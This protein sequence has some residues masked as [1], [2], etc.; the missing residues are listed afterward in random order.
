M[1]M[2]NEGSAADVALVGFDPVLGDGPLGVL[3][4]NLACAH[5]PVQYV[6]QPVL[7]PGSPP[8]MVRLRPKIAR[9]GRVSSQTKWD[10]VVFLVGVWV[11][12]T[13]V[14]LAQLLLL[15]PVRVVRRRADG[16]RPPGDA[17]GVP[18]VGLRHLGVDRAGRERGIWPVGGQG[19]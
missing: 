4:R 7:L 12:A 16:L 3:Q 19:C 17:D 5:P 1:V 6:F 8:G 9:V 2:V 14:V 11:R 18:D 15:Q 10:Q 13:Q